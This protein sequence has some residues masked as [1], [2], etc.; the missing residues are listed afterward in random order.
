M[1]GNV[2]QTLL[3]RSGQL[4]K[5]YDAQ[6]HG[7]KMA[8]FERHGEG[9]RQVSAE[10]PVTI[11]RNG[12]GKERE[13]D[14][15]TPTGLYPLGDVYGYE[16]IDTKMPFFRSD[17]KLVCVDDSASRYY[18]RIVDKIRVIED[19]SSFEQMRRDDNL[20]RYVVTVGYNRT[21]IPGRG[22][23]IFIHI[24]NGDKPTAGCIGMPEKALE[25]LVR[26]LDP[27]KR[28]VILIERWK[29]AARF[30]RL[31]VRE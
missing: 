27:K 22:S 13:G 30:A 11:G 17:E 23:C 20:Y 24:A 4:V 29:P 26:W 21:R 19:F 7:A 3:E 18:N 14:G 6:G 9:W 1:G 25:K 31:D 10:W 5:V 15:K 8:W 2:S 28:P 16:T 12:L